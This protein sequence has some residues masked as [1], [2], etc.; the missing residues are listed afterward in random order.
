MRFLGRSLLI[1]V[2]TAIPFARA[3]V[4]QDYGGKQ[5][6]GISGSY[7]PDSSHIL[8]GISE[9]RRTW[10]AGGEYTRRLFKR[11]R[12]RVDYTGSLNP[13]F[14]ESDPT[15]IGLEATLT[16]GAPPTILPLTPTR[17][18]TVD[19][20][21][22]KT[23]CGVEPSCYPVYNLYGRQ[24]TYGASIS[25]LGARI[26]LFPRLRL[27]PSFATDIGLLFSTRDLPID[28]TEKL[29][30]QFSFGPGVQ[31][32]SAHN[33]AARLELVYRHI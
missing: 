14:Q 7:A 28:D 8:I 13:F 2:L 25:P 16:P 17:V 20:A 10:T 1:V 19:H 4:G 32:F 31:V 22:I 3:Q 21:P 23:V 26:S 5:S 12:F 33:A 27:Q 29:N 6:F 18:V 24:S 15:L 9:Q 30:Y 11:D